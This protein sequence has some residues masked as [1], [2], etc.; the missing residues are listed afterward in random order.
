MGQFPSFT[1]RAN[2][3]NVLLPALVVE[4]QGKEAAGIIRQNRINADDISTKLVLASEM[5][6]NSLIR[7]RKQ[8]AVFAVG[9]TSL[10]LEA[11]TRLPLV[12]AGRRIAAFPGLC[13]LPPQ[14][15]HILPPAKHGAKQSNFL[16][17]RR[18]L[19]DRFHRQP[20]WLRRPA[21]RS[22]GYRSPCPPGGG[23]SPS[24]IPPGPCGIPSP[25]G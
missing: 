17:W 19:V 25:S 15:K 4:V 1:D 11:N 5:A 2:Q 21:G 12:A 9:A 20:R 23:R 22:A 24:S 7:Q 18:V 16:L 13:A 14:S 6:V 10:W 8:L 3:G